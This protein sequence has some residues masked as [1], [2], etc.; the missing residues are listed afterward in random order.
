M[1]V[2]RNESTV[3]NS[4]G[5]IEPVE[6]IHRALSGCA[7]AFQ[8]LV[9]RDT[10]R[11]LVLLTHRHRRNRA[12]AEDVIQEALLRAFQNLQRYDPRYEFRVWFYTIAFRISTDHLRRHQRDAR[13]M[14]EQAAMT[15]R[16]VRE[17]CELE[18]QESV[19][20]IWNTAEKV[21]GEYHF[22]VLWLSVGEELTNREIA[23]VLGRNAL[24]I[25]VA[26]HRAKKKL[27]AC[28]REDD[29]A[30]LPNFIATDSR[31]YQPNAAA[32]EQVA[33]KFTR[34]QQL[35]LHPTA[36]RALLPVI[37]TWLARTPAY[38]SYFTSRARV[39]D[40]RIDVGTKTS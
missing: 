31:H 28:L 19:E 17:P 16:P 23:R 25:R 6:L 34:L 8:E 38:S 22:S 20:G 29:R 12:D 11:L 32:S 40:L 24:S 1:Q 4:Q 10:P 9:M 5:A 35:N 13:R 21:L 33:S 37:F 26:V 27:M 14:G 39:P 30:P 3:A 7:D 18:Q 36:G 15:S 2:T